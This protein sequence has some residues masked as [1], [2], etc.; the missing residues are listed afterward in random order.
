MA[1][2]AS[3]IAQYQGKDL[4]LEEQKKMGQ[5][6]AAKMDAK[7]ED[8]MKHVLNLLSNKQID[9]WNP[10]SILKQE[11]YDALT[12]EWKMRVDKSL[13]NIADQ[14]RLIVE[15]RLSKETPDESPQLAEM[16]DYLWYMKEKIEEHHDVFKL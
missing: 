15:F 12:D 3:V 5:P 16:I 13:P 10:E 2:F 7:H 1:D 11:I 6:Q 8:F 14:L 4:T 9:P